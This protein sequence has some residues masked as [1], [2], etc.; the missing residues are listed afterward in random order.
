[1]KSYLKYFIK[2]V[3]VFALIMLMVFSFACSPPASQTP[4]STSVTPPGTTP[5][6]SASPSEIGNLSPTAPFTP[7][8]GSGLIPSWQVP[9]LSRDPLPADLSGI[10]AQILPSVVSINAEVTTTD[11]FGNPT[12]QQGAGSGWVIDSN[13]LI[14]TNN[15]VIQGAQNITISTPDGRN[16]PAQQILA[17]PLTDLAVIKINATGLPAVKLGDSA[18]LKQGMMVTAVGNSLGQGIRVTAGWVS[19]LSVSL[20]L[21]ATAAEPG[22]TLFDLIEVTAPINPGNSGGPLVDMLGEVVGITNA[23]LVASGVEAVGYAISTQT[24]L[25]ILQQLIQAGQVTRP[26][27]GAQFFDVTPMLASVYGF[28]VNR[29]AIIVQIDRGSPVDQAG[30]R[31]GDI[32]VQMDN[33]SISSAADALRFIL[34]SRIGQQISLTYYR[35]NTQ[36]SVQVTLV[37]NPGP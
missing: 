28:A 33:T 24:A 12:T 2:P 32:I 13:G 6:I 19:R 17:D 4:P 20:T 29:G 22:G 25:P 18:K 5:T 34:N 16:F 23:K 27:V 10:A 26:Y 14:V 15:H 31:P 7:F 3:T 9:E 11:I 21:P 37:Q 36:S 35:G 1:M 30:L 8:P